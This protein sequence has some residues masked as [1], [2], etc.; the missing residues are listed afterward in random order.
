MTMIFPES[1]L[2]FLLPLAQVVA[3]EELTWKEERIRDYVNYTFITVAAATCAALFWRL[4]SIL[5]RH[6]RRLRR[7]N[8]QAAAGGGTST[9]TSAFKKHVL[10]APMSRSRKARDLTIG[11]GVGIN[12]GMLPTRIEA[13][14]IATYLIINNVFI[15]V[16]IDYTADKGVFLYAIRNRSGAVMTANLVRSISTFQ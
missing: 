3:A 5:T 6:Q 12:F 8:D 2:L 11:P 1:V 4:G 7:V 13:V 9:I 16:D 14:F 10:Y 15:F